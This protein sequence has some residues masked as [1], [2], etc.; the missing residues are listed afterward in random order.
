[1]K[2]SSLLPDR[3]RNKAFQV[4]AGLALALA[5]VALSFTAAQAAPPL[6]SPSPSSSVAESAPGAK[7]R[8]NAAMGYTVRQMVYHWGSAVWYITD[9]HIKMTSALISFITDE[10][11]KTLTFY[12]DRS[13]KYLTMPIKNAHSR[14]KIYNHDTA[15]KWGT[16]KKVR[17]DS[18]S[19]EKVDVYVRLGHKESNDPIQ[20]KVE[21]RDETWVLPH[22]N[23]AMEMQGA[24]SELLRGTFS[25][26][27]PLRDV[28][29]GYIKGREARSMQRCLMT[30][31]VYLS[32]R[33]ISKTVFKVPV[34]Y[35]K[36][37]SEMEL[38][39]FSDDFNMP[40]P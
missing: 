17:E 34:G 36:A 9:D 2:V 25:H 22:V 18:L 7:G 40:S 24:A 16:A 30:D 37:D 28:R 12:S 1:M 38:M 26:G 23:F 8:S 14:L 6:T 27:F 11:A 21:F 13:R 15:Y 32:K 35:K 39:T 10:K 4:S 29:F 31:T 3:I 5:S 20:R 33:P 19:G